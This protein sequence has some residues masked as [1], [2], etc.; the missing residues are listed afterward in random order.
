VLET[1]VVLETGLPGRVTLQRI[2]SADA[3]A[4]A[5]HVEGDLARLSEHLP[6]PEL[7]RTPAGAAE[8]LGRYERREDG[9]VDVGGVW[10]G[11][12]L[13]GGALL[14]Q[15]HPQAAIVEIGCWL[16]AAAEGGGVASA[17]CRVLLGLARRDLR[18][19]RVEWHATTLNVRSRRLAE[20][21]GFTHEGTMR[22]SYVL[23]GDRLDTDVLSLVGGELDAFV[24]H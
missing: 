2:T 9:R 15:H 16:T 4:F 3:V 23:R 6:W 13:V 12:A 21:L 14:H 10:T 20:R 5:D 1:G 11:G 24:P 8:W 7:T 19:E 17:A 18:A 22:S